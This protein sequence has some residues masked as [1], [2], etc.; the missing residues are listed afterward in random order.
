MSFLKA[1]TSLALWDPS[2]GVAHPRSTDRSGT[3]NQQS[4]ACD[5]D[6][7]PAFDKMLFGKTKVES[8]TCLT[9]G[10]WEL[11]ENA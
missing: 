3:G 2:A 5:K 7:I 4:Q 10:I 11:P 9:D 6:L 1:S 8:S